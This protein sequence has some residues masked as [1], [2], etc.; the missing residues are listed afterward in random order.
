ML[1]PNSLLGGLFC[2][3][4]LS[5][6][7]M[8]ANTSAEPA[9]EKTRLETLQTRIDTLKPDP[10]YP[11][12]PYVLETL[13]EACAALRAKSGGI[14]AC[15]VDERT[16]AIIARG[17]NRQYTGYF[18]SDLHAEMDLLDRYEDGARKPLASAGG[19]PRVCSGLVLYSSV[20]PCPMC[21]TRIINSG[22]KKVYY[23]APDPEGGMVT[24]MQNLPP[25]WRQ[26]AADRTFLPARCAPEMRAL[27][28]ELFNYSIRNF[29][30]K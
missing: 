16:G 19:N 24:R 9:P 7:V 23:V 29:K 26:L 18:R 17:R 2:G 28:A 27:A 15:L 3:L 4:L 13:R 8:A 30:R 25:F 6:A 11:D 1:K 20:E 14:G 10:A 21:L 12:D 5:G 22:I